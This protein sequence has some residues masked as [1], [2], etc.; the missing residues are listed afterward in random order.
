MFAEVQVDFSTLDFRTEK[1]LL[2]MRSSHLII[3]KNKYIILSS[4]NLFWLHQ[5]PLFMVVFVWLWNETTSK[6]W[7]EKKNFRFSFNVFRL[8]TECFYS[9]GYLVKHKMGNISDFPLAAPQ[10][11]DSRL[12]CL[13]HM[14]MTVFRT[15]FSLSQGG[16]DK[17]GDLRKSFF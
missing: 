7:I 11:L 6:F 15:C 5:I 14:L 3:D 8:L 2:D 9:W 12:D 4:I 1:K 10:T 16:A 17:L 13:L